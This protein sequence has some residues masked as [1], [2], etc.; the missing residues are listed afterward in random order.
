MAF[1]P[2]LAAAVS[3]A[4]AGVAVALSAFTHDSGAP[5]RP[6]VPVGRPATTD[7]AVAL[8]NL[9]GSIRQARTGEATPEGRARLVDLLLTRGRFLGRI[10]DLEEAL[11]IAEDSALRWPSASA[12]ALARGS[13]LA[14]FH[15]FDEARAEL[16]RAG[17]LGAPRDAVDSALA[18][19][20][21]ATG[22]V[23][24]A[25][26]I[27]EELSR[28]RATLSRLAAEAVARAA[29]SRSD[30]ETTF[31][32]AL[33][34]RA[35]TSPFPVA[36]LLFERG[37]FA[38]Q[39]S[40]LKDARRWLQ[41]AVDVLPG[42]AAAKTHLGEVEAELGD[43]PQAIALLSEVAA[44]TDDPDAAGQLA[45][46]LLES[47][48]AES[49][50]VWVARASAR[51]DELLARHP[52]AFADHAAEF[53]LSAGGDPGRALAL[54]ER[55]ARLRPTKPACALWERASRQ[56]KTSRAVAACAAHRPLESQGTIGE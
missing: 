8:S 46:V 53:Y 36:W 38:I 7:G 15:R 2:V 9:A 6:P 54:A 56:T 55:N 10:V 34:A 13:A 29:A 18:A 19:I 49:A 45:R 30:A 39:E 16:A 11:T 5:T 51:Y 40:R 21:T 24:D 33:L 48:R 41:A 32:R 3:L 23:G 26:A 37:R 27:R 25:I 4:A 44:S 22:R 28:N 47:G 31:A 17:R 52:D 50:K 43:V 1:R 35:D 20:L 14:T 42:Y 12:S